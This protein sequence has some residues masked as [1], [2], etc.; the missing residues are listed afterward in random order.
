MRLVIR[1][2]FTDLG[3]V[4]LTNGWDHVGRQSA[5]D[6]FGLDRAE[7]FQR[8]EMVFG[9]YEEGQ[10]TLDEYLSFAVF[11]C[12]RPFS[13]AEFTSYIKEQ[14]QPLP[15][16]LELM[17]SAKRES[18][19]P[20]FALSN[21]GRELAQ[22]RIDTFGLKNLADAFIVSGFVGMRKPAMGIYRL[23]LDVAQVAPH[24]ALYVDDRESLIEAGARAGLITLLHQDVNTTTEALQRHGLLK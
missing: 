21:E 2:I 22:Y 15:G 8:H 4:I 6:Q 20:V 3:G 14:S 19:L 5:V 7:F 10:M 11:Y 12:A 16:M 1:A 18:G 17:L 9:A 24:E 13:K 23:T